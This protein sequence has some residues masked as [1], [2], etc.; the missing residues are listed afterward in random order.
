M[1]IKKFYNWHVEQ[2]NLQFFLQIVLNI[3]LLQIFQQK[4]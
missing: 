4:W 3:G 1:K 2:D